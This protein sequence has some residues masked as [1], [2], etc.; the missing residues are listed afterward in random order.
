MHAMT[1]QVLFKVCRLYDE[2][3]TSSLS[4]KIASSVVTV[5]IL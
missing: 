5:T 3:L 2:S 4:L 1:L